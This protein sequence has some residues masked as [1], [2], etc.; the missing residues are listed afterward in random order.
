M[1]EIQCKNIFIER[2]KDGALVSTTVTNTIETNGS[3]TAELS[4]T[5]LIVRLKNGKDEVIKTIVY[6]APERIEIT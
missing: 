5:F 1:T 6:W 3:M 4:D 2:I